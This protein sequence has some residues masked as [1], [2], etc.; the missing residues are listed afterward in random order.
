MPRSI[1]SQ[2]QSVNVAGFPRSH[3]PE[4]P[5]GPGMRRSNPVCVRRLRPCR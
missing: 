4:N 3:Q 1:E 5:P 2:R